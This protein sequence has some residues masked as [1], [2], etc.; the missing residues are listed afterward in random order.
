VTPE[1][2]TVP[3]EPTYAMLCAATN[4][5]EVDCS[6]DGNEHRPPCTHVFTPSHDELRAIWRTMFQARVREISQGRAAD[7]DN[8]LDPTDAAVH[9]KGK[10]GL[11]FLTDEQ[12][13]AQMDRPDSTW[14]CPQCGDWAP[15]DGTRVLVVDESRRVSVAWWKHDEC[16]GP[17]GKEIGAWIDGTV[18]DWNMQEYRHLKPVC[19]KPIP[20]LQPP[21]VGEA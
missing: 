6:F 16:D 14:T 13:D 15:K 1:S 9:C 17:F 3:L 12:Y 7:R 2:A 20:D 18:A 8:L 19:W 4:E 10:C 11:V 5:C 21:L